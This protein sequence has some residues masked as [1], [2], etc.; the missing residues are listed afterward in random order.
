MQTQKILN[1]ITNSFSL[2]FQ[3]CT[4]APSKFS[5]STL[6]VLGLLV[7]KIHTIC[8]LPCSLKTMRVSRYTLARGGAGEFLEPLAGNFVVQGVYESLA[9]HRC[10]NSELIV[11]LLCTPD[12]STK[13]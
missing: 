6:V 1:K 7:V 11:S 3:V 13:N 5:Q 10:F 12:L 2:P 8:P 9:L 4:F